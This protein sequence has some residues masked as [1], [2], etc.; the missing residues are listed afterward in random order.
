MRAP[1]RVLGLAVASAVALA[2]SGC[3]RDVKP[4]GGEAFEGGV[5]EGPPPPVLGH[6]GCTLESV[7]ACDEW[8]RALTR[9]GLGVSICREGPTRCVRAD[10]CTAAEGEWRCGCGNGPPC[11][12]GEVCVVPGTGERGSCRRA[13][14]AGCSG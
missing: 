8:A 10:V 4:A 13:V 14:G 7:R 12:E 11:G 9:E 1:L 5:C 6:R 3:A 2:A